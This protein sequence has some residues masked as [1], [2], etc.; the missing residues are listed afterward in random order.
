MSEFLYEKLENEFVKPQIDAK[1]FYNF[2]KENLN[3]KFEFREYQ[4]EAFKRFFYYYESVNV[5]KQNHICFNM[6]TGSG[7]TLIM[8]GLILYLYKKGYRNFLFFVNRSQIVEKTKENFINQ[9][10]NK[11]LFN[12][13]IIIDNRLVKISP[14]SNFENESDDINIC[15]TTIQGLFSDLNT[16][17]EN[18]LTFEDFKDKKIVLIAD[19]A[20]H[21][22]AKTKKGQLAF[23]FNP[24]WENT[25]DKIFKSN[26]QN[27]LLEFSATI[28][29]D[30]LSVNEKYKDKILFKYDLKEFVK[31]KFSKNIY[32]FR[33]DADKKDRMLQAI[34]VSIFRQ[35]I[36]L[37]Y[38]INLK[39]VVLFKSKNI[40]ES[41][42]NMKIFIDLIENLNTSKISE[43]KKNN[44]IEVLH[45]IFKNINLTDL[46]EILK[47][48]FNHKKIISTNNDK[49]LENN[50]KI[51]NSL[52][53][54]N[55]PIRAIFTVDKLNEGWDVLNLFDI[56]RLYEG[57]N[58][59]G[60]NKGKVGRT[61]I[62]EA[63]LIGRGA[64]YFPFYFN[65]RDRFK[66]K[67]DEDVSNELKNLETLY[68]YSENES[69][70]ISELRKALSEIGLIEKEESNPLK[71]K[72]K[73]EF[74]TKEFLSK[75]VYKNKKVKKDYKQ[76]KL[77]DFTDLS[78]SNFSYD[79][80]S[81]FG[82]LQKAFDENSK[83][84]FENQ[85]KIKAVNFVEFCG[86][87]VIKNAVLYNGYFCMKNLK[88][89]LPNLKNMEE[90]IKND[91]YLRQFN[92][93]ISDKSLN[94]KERLDLAIEF[95][96][97]LEKDIKGKTYEFQG[98]KKFYAYEFGK[99][100]KLEKEIK[101]SGKIN[102]CNTLSEKWYVYENFYGTDEEEY[103][104]D[105]MKKNLA[106]YLDKKYNEFYL[107][108]NERDLAI[109]DFENGARFEPDFLLFLKDE[110]YSY[111]IFI[112]PKGDNLL[113][114]DDWKNSFLLNIE[115][116]FEIDDKNFKIIGVKFYNKANEND[117]IDDFK[118]KI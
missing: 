117:F 64:R 73:D 44:K 32:L 10:S 92:I 62:S 88:R 54:D 74:K 108:R 87:N 114:Q 60:N 1:E 109:Y 51:L 83:S 37:K 45:D 115:S 59:G 106:D 35:K 89:I 80:K 107:V 7:K 21:I 17:K 98:S 28:E 76:S 40:K 47:V 82:V 79:V 49:D 70:Y 8:A 110:S 101:R 9:S 24:T 4:I 34:I 15:F 99:I 68:Y 16:Q 41:E 103:F 95:L 84:S 22:N 39:P 61:T 12:D 5:K 38:K 25:V 105:L 81:G 50:Q 112:E 36:A 55:N 11:Y 48:E 77:S 100:F 3:P 104:F 2:V 19:E 113:K 42:E 71:L 18:S 53:D 78:K 63:Q 14:V 58:S 93:N 29:L 26:S 111:Q 65:E 20:H 116:N 13:K 69:N 96:N 33:S 90:F 85:A 75:K 31:N 72:L 66:R 30:N 27:L 46:A 67:F 43:F 56:V 23:D 94:H 97:H 52:E 6:A 86:E 57:Q 91:E 118:S 102:Q